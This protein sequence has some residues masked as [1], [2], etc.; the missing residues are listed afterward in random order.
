MVW[1][2]PLTLV[3]LGAGALVRARFR[4]N[5]NRSLTTEPVSSEWLAESRGRS[6]HHW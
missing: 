3:V 2:I 5:R 1:L 4:R 6:E